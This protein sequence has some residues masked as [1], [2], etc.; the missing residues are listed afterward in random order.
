MGRMCRHGDRQYSY[1]R[2]NVRTSMR[3]FM[4]HGMITSLPFQTLER[5]VRGF[6]CHRRIQI[7][8]LLEQSSQ[9]LSLSQIS[10]ACRA[11][12]KPVCEHVGRLHLA[13][14]VAKRKRGRETLHHLT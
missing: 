5:T 4:L 1:V 3:W 8:A 12:I 9:A 7:M 14:L 10:M 13:G 2:T 11:G 6:S